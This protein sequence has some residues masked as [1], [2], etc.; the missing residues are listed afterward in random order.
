MVASAIK[1]K[2][3]DFLNF[4]Y[5]S[6]LANL[7]INFNFNQYDFF[8]PTKEITEHDFTK[9]AKVN[10]LNSIQRHLHRSLFF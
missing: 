4:F 10:R 3:D 9:I 7:F 6:H 2:S 8:L 5:C 1:I